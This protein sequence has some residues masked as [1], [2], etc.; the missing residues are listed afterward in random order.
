MMILG[1]FAPC[2]FICNVSSRASRQRVLDA[3][4]RERV[5]DG[6]VAGNGP[7]ARRHPLSV[8]GRDLEMAARCIFS[9]RD[10]AIRSASPGTTIESCTGFPAQIALGKQGSS[11]LGTDVSIITRNR[12]APLSEDPPGRALL[13]LASPAAEGEG[14]GD[15]SQ[16]TS[17]D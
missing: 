14:P 13:Q 7:R 1:V 8:V 16:F 2:M 12:A 17:Q 10:Q 15:P 9:P 3:T 6:P 11:M 4:S 5:G